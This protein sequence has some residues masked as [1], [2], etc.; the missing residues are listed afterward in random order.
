MGGSR[1]FLAKVPMTPSPV[2]LKVE[3]A[4]G[5]RAKSSSVRPCLEDVTYKVSRFSPPQ[6]AEVTRV[7]GSCTDCNSWLVSGSIRITCDS[8]VI[9]MKF[10]TMLRR[11]YLRSCITRHPQLS[12][13]IY[14][15]GVRH[16]S[17]VIHSK[18]KKWTPI[19]LKNC[20]VC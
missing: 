18:V 8:Q 6:T 12:F 20:T 9:K 11:P 17:D 5:C 13:R 7:T 3:P 15:H 10:Q 1:T 2:I 16:S 19:T 14:A 4:R